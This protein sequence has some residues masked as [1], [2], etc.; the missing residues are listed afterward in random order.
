MAHE[1]PTR[2]N[3][4]PSAATDEMME[5]ALS[6]RL[7]SDRAAAREARRYAVGVALRCA[8]WSLAGIACILWSAHTTS[9]TYGRIAFYFG[10]MIGNAGVL[11]TLTA[12]YVRGERRGYW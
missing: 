1:E 6:S 7:A 9:M 8:A 12:A 2:A 5:E 11:W 10:V 4:D 3:V